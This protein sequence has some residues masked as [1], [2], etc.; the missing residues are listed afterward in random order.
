MLLLT[1]LGVIAPFQ[2][3]T[4]A[5]GTG[6]LLVYATVLAALGPLAN[7]RKSHREVSIKR[8]QV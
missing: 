1:L 7:P 3:G 4:D 5:T 8:T 6:R 2:L